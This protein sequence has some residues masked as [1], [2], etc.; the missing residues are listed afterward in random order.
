MK[1]KALIVALLTVFLMGTLAPAAAYAETSVSELSVKP[2]IVTVGEYSRYQITFRTHE[3]L[4]GGLDAIYIRFPSEYRFSNVSWYEGYVDINGQ[5]S[6]GLNYSSGLLSVLIPRNMTIGINETVIVGLSQAIMRNPDTTGEFS[7]SLSTSKE[8][9]PVPSPFF[10]ISE[11]VSTNGVSRPNVTM[12]PIRGYQA[13]EIVIRFITNRNGQLIGGFDQIILDFPSNFRIPSYIDPKHITINGTQ[14]FTFDPVTSGQRL[15]LPLSSTMNFMENH[16]IEIVIAPNAGVTVDRGISDVRLL[17][18]TTK[19]TATVESLP[20]SANRTPDQV[21]IP[22]DDRDPGVAVAPNGAGALGQWTFT[23][24]RNTILLTQ[25]EYVMGFTIT[26]PNGTVLPGSIAAQHITVNGQQCASVLVIPA[27]RQI[28]FSMPVGF[29]VGFDI[30]VAI[31]SSAGIQ[32]PPAAVY[33]MEITPLNSIKTFT[34]KAF[35]IKTISDAVPSTPQNPTVTADRVVKVTLNDPVATKDGLAMILDVAPQ[36]MDGFTMIPLR[37]VTEGLG[38][39]VDYDSTQNTV[40]LILGSRTI[41]LWPGSTLAKVDNVVV[42][43]A[44][45]PIIVDG[46]TMVP[47]RFV[48]ECF[49]AKVDFVSTTDPITITLTADALN[50]MPTVAEIQAA[51]QAAAAGSGGTGSGSGTGSGT[52]SDPGTGT[53]AGSNPGTGNETSGSLVGKTVA[54]QAGRN[55]V[56]LRNGPGTDHDIVGLFIGNETAK[57]LEV[58]KGP[59][60]YDWYH[61]EFSY[62]FKG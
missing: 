50:R 34:T 43:L 62:G 47:V 53:G 48:S 12:N 7:F 59:D 19:N 32:N 18:S 17:V 30:T 46:R 27:S 36:L 52:G 10:M 40:T 3:T 24:T 45:A 11:F 44:K 15:I 6:A 25:G 4:T 58:Q 29:S 37:F 22:P 21:Y 41:V 8:N 39:I 16:Q 20:F 28:I 26:F 14:M 56:R 1:K 42:T 38:A 55:D 61:V 23:F 9:I 35:E 51:Q 31:S 54:V 57:I 13:E 60:N 5:P 49:G 2:D 33:H